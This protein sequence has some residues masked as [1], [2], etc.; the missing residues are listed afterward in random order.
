MWKYALQ[1]GNA[2]RFLV[3]MK[4]IFFLTDHRTGYMILKIRDTYHGKDGR[5]LKI[6]FSF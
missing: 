1:S 4:N 2:G 5:E 6:K 3:I